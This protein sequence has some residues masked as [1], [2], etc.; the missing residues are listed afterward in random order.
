MKIFIGTLKGLFRI[1]VSENSTKISSPEFIG[2]SVYAIGRVGKQIWAAPST[3]WTGTQLSYSDDEGE[4]WETVTPPLA[5]PSNTETALK[6]VWQIT[7]DKY[8]KLFCGTEPAALFTSVDNGKTWQLCEGL[9]NHPHREKWTPGF[10]GLGLH[11]ILPLSEKVWVIGIST[12]GVYRTEDGGETWTASNQK[13][14]APFLPEPLPEFGQ[15]VHKISVDYS[16][17]KTLLL[18]HHWGVYRSTDAGK[19]WENVGKDKLPTDF[20]FTT[21]M[22]SPNC[23]FIIPIKADAERIFP[24]G[25]MRVYRT[26][27]AGETWQPLSNGLPQNDVYDCVLRDSF[28]ADGKNLAFG[29][30]GGKV[31][32]SNDDGENWTS[33]AEH[34]PRISC[35]RLV[36]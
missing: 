4:T 36:V 15:C 32:L 11:T 3:E 27:D 1:D 12:G 25:K 26:R 34:L 16:D 20:G 24:D 7:A 22:N 8:G 9:W 13:I 30:T 5:F 18:Q 35:V 17:T 23:G 31:Y 2:Q 10:G 6:Q 14:V 19:S 29:T 28:D 33:I 21:V